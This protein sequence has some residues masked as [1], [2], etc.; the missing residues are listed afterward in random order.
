[1][2]DV[3]FMDTPAGRI[4]LRAEQPGDEAFLF[5]LFRSHALPELAQ[6]PVDQATREA[7]TRMQFDSQTRTYRANFPNAAFDILEL[8]GAP[9]GRLLVDDGG[10]EGCVVDFALLPERQ[11]GGLG[12]AVMRKVVERFALMG[13]AVRCKVLTHNAA[14]MRMCAKAG[15]ISIAEI[16]PFLQLEWRP[17]RIV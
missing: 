12:T 4:A 11:G 14:S 3:R 10:N 9:I 7:L 2:S 17:A 16:P 5:A 8:D 6:M 13:R 1:M 15:F